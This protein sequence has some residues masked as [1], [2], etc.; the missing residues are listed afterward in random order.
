[1]PH[2]EKGKKIDFGAAHMQI[3]PMLFFSHKKSER[4]FRHAHVWRIHF[5]NSM[6]HLTKEHKN[7]VWPKKRRVVTVCRNAFCQSTYPNKFIS[8]MIPPA[9]AQCHNVRHTAIQSKRNDETTTRRREKKIQRSTNT[10]HYMVIYDRHK[11]WNNICFY[12]F[13]LIIAGH[14]VNIVR[15][16]YLIERGRV[17][18]EKK[19]TRAATL[20][21]NQYKIQQNAY[22][23][24][25]WTE[26]SEREGQRQAWIVHKKR[27]VDILRL[28]HRGCKIYIN[29][30]KYRQSKTA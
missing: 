26:E 9:T 2:F 7:R 10:N 23:W 25:K 5:A 12:L 1:M 15:C 6:L 30:S 21:K 11:V 24:M 8:I 4:N 16:W 17:E 27:R 14:I 3:R 18:R 29:K 28:L 20:I 22:K 19:H 13:E